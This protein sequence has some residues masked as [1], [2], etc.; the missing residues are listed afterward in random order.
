MSIFFRQLPDMWFEAVV[1]VATAGLLYF[2]TS[3]QW[4]R[5]RNAVP[6]PRRL[7]LIGNLLDMK[8][9]NHLTMKALVAKYG[10]IYAMNFMGQQVFFVNSIE[11]AWDVLIRKGNIFAGRTESYVT[12]A[13]NREAEAIISGDFGPRWKLLRKVAHSALRM[14]GTGIK[15]L[16][17]KVVREVEEVCDHLRGLR[18]VPFRP[19]EVISFAA[20]NMICFTLFGMRYNAGHEDINDFR[21]LIDEILHL[22]GSSALLEVFP[23]MKYLPLDIHKRI[24]HC[25]RLTDKLLVPQFQEHMKTY[26]EGSI[27]DITDA[28][29]K[30]LK[31]AE[32]E[33][34]K[35]KELLNEN[36]LIMTLWDLF[37][38]GTDTTS[39]CLTWILLYLATFPEVQ[40]KVQQELK[41]GIGSQQPVFHDRKSLPY[42]E[43]TITEVM[44]HSS[45]VYESLP[46]RVRSS[47]TLGNYEIPESSQVIIDFRAIHH[48][49]R[50]W[51]KPDCFD[52]TRFLDADGNHVCPASF[53]FL[54]FGA[55]PRGC[56]GQ[57]LAKIEIFLFMARLLQQFEFVF[58]PGSSQPDLEPFVGPI[59]RGILSPK[60]FELCVVA[61]DT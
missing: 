34:S 48:D 7:P 25:H 17:Q 28:L 27:R 11:L 46:H 2:L 14:Y 15:N 20:M 4:S 44:R 61:R 31:D 30:A 35:V 5:P 57:T 33:D 6:G 38:A 8:N 41:D 23:F 52:P 55:G 16:E 19:S 58:P 54:P 42:L 22:F 60:P 26:Q 12:H 51:N 56:L 45:F 29:I 32:S 49:P 36:H 59:Q 1:L 37:S 50:H 24:K 53:S 47:T 40:R 9:F 10:D 3:H 39:S 21:I 13:L 18:G 43:A